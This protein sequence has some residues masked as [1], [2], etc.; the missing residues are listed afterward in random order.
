[1]RCV[2]SGHCLLS[3]ASNHCLLPAEWWATHAN[4]GTAA[5]NDPDLLSLP[6]T[7]HFFRTTRKTEDLN[8]QVRSAAARFLGNAEAFS[9]RS[10]NEI[11]E[12]KVIE[13]RFDN[14][15]KFHPMNYSSSKN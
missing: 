2:G 10:T 6:R 3:G 9:A 7:K 12:I 13:M 11:I 1:M 5:E 15:K 14:G 4:Y 8:E